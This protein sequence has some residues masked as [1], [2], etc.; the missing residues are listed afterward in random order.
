MKEKIEDFNK[1]YEIEKEIGRWLWFCIIYNVKWKESNKNAEPKETGIDFFKDFL[2][3]ACDVNILQGKNK[4]NEN[5]M[6]IDEFYKTENEYSNVI[7]N[8]DN[9]LFNHLDDKNE[10]FNT[11]EIYEILK[12]LNR[13]YI[14][15]LK[16]TDDSCSLNDVS[17]LIS[18]IIENNKLKICSPEKNVIYGVLEY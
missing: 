14:V 11:E 8:C 15:K 1:Y 4:E 3:E 16:L 6:F 9:N 13:V 7:E 17:N 18:S 5:A 2:K 12:Q 10:P